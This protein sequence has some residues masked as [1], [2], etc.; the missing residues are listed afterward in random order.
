MLRVLGKLQHEGQSFEV[1]EDEAGP[2]VMVDGE[3]C[4]ARSLGHKVAALEQGGVVEVMHPSRQEVMF[5]GHMDK[6]G[7]AMEPRIEQP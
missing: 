1:C 4:R 6:S 7:L 5:W 2:F 3:R